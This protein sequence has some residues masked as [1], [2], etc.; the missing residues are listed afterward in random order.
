MIGRSKN[1][2]KYRPTTFLSS[3]VAGQRTYSNV[4]V[5]ESDTSEAEGGS[6]IWKSYVNLEAGL[7]AFED[8]KDHRL[9]YIHSD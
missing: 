1:E 4:Y 3:F 7:I 5:Y 8:L 2:Q 6:F 9:Y